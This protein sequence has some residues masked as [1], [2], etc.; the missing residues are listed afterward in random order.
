MFFVILGHHIGEAKAY[1]VFTSPIKLPLFFMITGFVFNYGRMEIPSFFRN[2]FFKLIVPWLVLTVPLVLLS[3]VKNG[4]SAI[5]G[6]LLDIVSG[7]TAWYMP[8]LIIA[9][10]IWFFIC[11]L[12]KRPAARCLTAV[13]VCVLGLLAG[14]FGILDFAMINRAMTAQLFILFGYLFL[15]LEDKLEK[16]GWLHIIP[17]A[18]AYIAM[19]FITLKVWP[20][21][22][23]DVHMSRYYNYPFCFFMILIGC[24]T[25]FA[26]AKKLNEGKGVPV[27]R[28]IRFLGQTTL[29]YYLLYSVN[30]AVLIYALSALHIKLPPVAEVIACLVFGYAACWLEAK[31]ILRFFP[32]V[33]GKR[34]SKSK[35]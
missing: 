9:E 13:S 8:C 22:C 19:G 34:R 28:A 32:W 31:L 5:P 30:T 27:L 26:A 24:F 25:L 29:V 2:L 20:G 14:E 35:A 6:G 15:L 17:L 12:L 11:K 21:Q 16:L 18:A 4:A 23:I 3:A 10:I 1:F 33:L 7:E